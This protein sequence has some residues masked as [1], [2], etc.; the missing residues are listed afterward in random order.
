MGMTETSSPPYPSSIWGSPKVSKR[1]TVANPHSHCSAAPYLGVPCASKAIHQTCRYKSRGVGVI[2]PGM[3]QYRPGIGSADNQITEAPPTL[4]RLVRTCLASTL[5][6]AA[7]T[8]LTA[9]ASTDPSLPARKM[10]DRIPITFEANRR[11]FEPILRIL[12]RGLC[13]SPS[14]MSTVLNLDTGY[15]PGRPSDRSK[16]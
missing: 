5:Y 7:L 15:P 11:H 8:S 6:S 16:P 2:K 13:Y 9:A 1:F 4:R 10:L 12:L 3:Q 14:L